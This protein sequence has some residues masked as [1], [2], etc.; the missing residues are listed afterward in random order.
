MIVAAEH[1]VKLSNV[2][3][4]QVNSCLVIRFNPLTKATVAQEKEQFVR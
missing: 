3:N 2:H 1:I 4:L